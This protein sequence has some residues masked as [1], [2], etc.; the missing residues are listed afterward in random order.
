[1]G[2][3]ERASRGRKPSR[4]EVAEEALRRASAAGGSPVGVPALP[5]GA[6]VPLRELPAAPALP[7]APA[8]PGVPSVPAAPPA[9]T[10]PG[11]TPPDD[12]LFDDRPFHEFDPECEFD[13]DEIDEVEADDEDWDFD[14]EALADPAFGTGD[15]DEE[16]E[17]EDDIED[18]SDPELHLA[19]EDER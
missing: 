4:R 8:I 13:V 17:E 16:P 3:F 11:W 10:V 19:E 12:E 6:E 1:M 18:W 2:L 7:G 14:D 15:A 9:P 5:P